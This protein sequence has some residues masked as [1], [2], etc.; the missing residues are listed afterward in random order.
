MARSHIELIRQ[1]IEAFNRRDFDAVLARL[2]P[3]VEFDWSRRLLDAEI[4]Y[5]HEGFQ[6]FIQQAGELFEDVHLDEPAK[7]IE[8]GDEIVAESV[9]RFRGRTSG[10]DVTAR[11]ATVWR[12]DGDKVTRFR[13][14]QSVQDAL[15]ELAVEQSGTGRPAPD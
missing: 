2:A 14:F 1:I 9:A 3:D 8:V 12:L 6:R 11:G 7:F 4:T 5:G 15:D 13:F 10:A